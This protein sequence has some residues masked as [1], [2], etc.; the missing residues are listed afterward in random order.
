MSEPAGQSEHVKP[1]ALEEECGVADPS[2][3]SVKCS[4]LVNGS[5]QHSNGANY[6]SG[7]NNT[8]PGSGR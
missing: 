2:D 7:G 6:H 5:G 3:P 8:W 4:W 1:A